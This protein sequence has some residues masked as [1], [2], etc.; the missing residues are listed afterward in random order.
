M[1]WFWLRL[2]FDLLLTVGLFIVLGR[3]TRRLRPKRIKHGISLFAPALISALLILWVIFMTGPKLLDSLRIPAHSESVR[4]VQIL[5]VD[6]YLARLKTSAGLSFYYDPFGPQPEE[7]L[8]YSLRFLPLSRYVISFERDEVSM[9][10]N[11]G[12]LTE[13]EAQSGEV[14]ASEEDSKRG[15]SSP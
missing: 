3:V 10:P 14:E 8:S 11:R 1:N 4:T 5:A 12:P 9:D 7:G 2:V 15:D 6:R 13:A